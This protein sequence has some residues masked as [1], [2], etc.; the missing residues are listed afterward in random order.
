MINLCAA[1]GQRLQ[2][3]RGF[4]LIALR[5]NTQRTGHSVE[6]RPQEEARGAL[7]PRDTAVAS[8]GQF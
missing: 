4:A 8:S 2:P 6:Q 7:I 3:A 5:F 1:F